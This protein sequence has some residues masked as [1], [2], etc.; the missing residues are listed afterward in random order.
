[1]NR[2]NEII[3]AALHLF[4]QKGIRR[5]NMDEVSSHLSIS[6]KTLYLYVENKGDL[7]E[8][9]FKLYQSRI[10]DFINTIQEKNQNPID[11]LF[12][13]DEQVGQMLQNRPEML[14]HDLKKYHPSVWE[15]LEV[16]KKEH[17]L[18]CVTQN[19][20]RG[21]KLGLY[22]TSVNSDIISKLML[23]TSDALIDDQLFP[24]N[25]YDF[26]SLLKENRIYHIRGIA[27][28]KG[29]NYLEEKLNHE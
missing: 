27:T 15:I 28:N 19:I 23:N 18:N 21:K 22:R 7:L 14:V 29:V 12:E 17:V 13:I 20:E 9:C 1:M 8:K 3:E 4:L 2:Y 6:K 25:Q 11:E 5:I 10:L 16:V 24:L 26:E